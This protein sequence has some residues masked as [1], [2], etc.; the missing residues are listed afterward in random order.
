M[1]P[2]VETLQISHIPG[3]NKS[4]CI[5][6]FFPHICSYK[7]CCSSKNPSLAA[8]RSSIVA[9]LLG[10]S[11]KIPHS[12]V[13]AVFSPRRWGVCV[14]EGACLGSCLLVK[15]GVAMWV[16]YC[17]KAHSFQM[18]PQTYTQFSGKVGHEL[19]DSWLT[20]RVNWQKEGVAAR[21]WPVT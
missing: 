2:L 3:I 4:M 14:F 17:K 13:S 19:K 15:G 12:F 16:A 10:R 11:T 6:S 7:W 20:V 5:V 21:E 9:L 8:T 18:S 1:Q